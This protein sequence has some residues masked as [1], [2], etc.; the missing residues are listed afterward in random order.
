MHFLPAPATNYFKK[1]RLSVLG[2]IFT[3]SGD[4]S[5]SLYLFLTALAPSKKAWLLAPASQTRL[6]PWLRFFWIIHFLVSIKFQDIYFV[7]LKNKNNKDNNLQP[8]YHLKC[9]IFPHSWINGYSK[10][11]HPSN[12]YFFNKA[13]IFI[14][15]SGFVSKI[16]TSCA[17]GE[18]SVLN[19]AYLIWVWF[20]IVY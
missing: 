1:A 10:P 8:L 20:V 5:G 3:V 11:G 18:F 4:S 2:G 15:D 14:L 9:Q 13:L 17:S 16:K 19:S 12:N 6:Q 7:V